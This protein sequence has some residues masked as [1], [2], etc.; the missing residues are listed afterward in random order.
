MTKMLSVSKSDV[1]G[2]QSTLWSD[3]E[4]AINGNEFWP[5]PTQKRVVKIPQIPKSIE[6]NEKSGFKWNLNFE[7]SIILVTS[8]PTRLPTSFLKHKRH[9]GD[10]LEMSRKKAGQVC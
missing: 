8:P 3:I 2:S 5:L 7:M 6:I 1:N 9:T 10:L 4:S